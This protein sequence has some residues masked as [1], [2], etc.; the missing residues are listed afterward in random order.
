M[1]VMTPNHSAITGPN[2][3][4][5]FAVPIGWIANRPIRI[6]T[7]AGRMYGLSNGVAMSRPSSADS[8]EIA[9]VTAPS[10]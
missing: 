2:A 1:S 4:P 9:G 10:P 7:A 6:A 3:L 8:T 5:I